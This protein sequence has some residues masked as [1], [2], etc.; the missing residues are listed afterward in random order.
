MEMVRYLDGTLYK[1]SG[2]VFVIVILAF[3]IIRK[4]S[5]P[6]LAREGLFLPKQFKVPPQHLDNTSMA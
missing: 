2:D 1:L 4:S 5:T 6:Y 3:N